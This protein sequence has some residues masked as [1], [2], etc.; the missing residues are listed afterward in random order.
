MF[1]VVLSWRESEALS[2]EN[3]KVVLNS[4]GQ[5]LYFSR[6]PI[7]YRGPWLRH[8]GIYGFCMESLDKYVSAPHG[9]LTESEDLEQLRWL[10]AGGSISVAIV[11]EALPSVD[12]P[13]HLEALRLL[14][15]N[16]KLKYP[17]IPDEMERF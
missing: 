15:R 6:A 11:D 9:S 16:G 4:A 2:T 7:P 17:I 3:V 13:E 8:L 5:A 14:V 12:T 10:E 1:H